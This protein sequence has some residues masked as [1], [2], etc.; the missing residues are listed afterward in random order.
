[1]HDILAGYDGSVSAQAAIRFAKNLAEKEGARLHILTVARLPDWGKLAY[2][3]PEL[4]ET[5]KR[6]CQDLIT[7]LK[8]EF[9]PSGGTVQYEVIVGH[10]AK[11]LVLY[12]ERHNI[13]HVVVGHRGHTPFDRWLL[14]SIARQVIAYAPCSV[15][16]VRDRPDAAKQHQ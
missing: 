5:E 4:L 14:G 10:P 12:A 9:G 6:H 2:E 15:T 8:E 11:E 1:M 16:I 7:G 13:D 3:R